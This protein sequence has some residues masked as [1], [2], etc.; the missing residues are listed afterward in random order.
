MNKHIELVK[1][2]L[3][4]PKSVTQQELQDNL[5]D[6]LATYD[7]AIAANI[8]A[9]TAVSATNAAYYAAN[10]VYA[11]TASYAAFKTHFVKY[12]VEQYEELTK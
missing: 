3:A 2:W 6:A 11:E 5:D 8:A 7:S 9:N 10:T 1:K 4:N 12:W